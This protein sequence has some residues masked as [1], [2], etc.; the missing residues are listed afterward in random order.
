MP[1]QSV[2]SFPLI[3]SF[4][5]CLLYLVNNI[6]LFIALSSL[7]FLREELAG[8]ELYV[9]GQVSD[10]FIYLPEDFEELFPAGEPQ[11]RLVG[12]FLDQGA[13]SYAL[14]VGLSK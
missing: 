5:C 13:A 4:L 6:C 2:I 9:P 11:G 12:Y 14:P 1:F 7:L 3:L 10:T 8:Q